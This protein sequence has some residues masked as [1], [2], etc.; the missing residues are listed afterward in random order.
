LDS[1]QGGFFVLPLIY[2]F[3]V[4]YLILTLRVLVMVLFLSRYTLVRLSFGPCTDLVRS[5]F[6]KHPNEVR[7]RCERKRTESGRRV[8]GD[9][10][11]RRGRCP[12]RPPLLPRPRLSVSVPAGVDRGRAFPRW[13]TLRAAFWPLAEKLS[14][15]GIASYVRSA[16]NVVPGSWK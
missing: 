6:G 10:N 15:N 4:S 7:T 8:D 14:F 16:K 2:S 5:C 3:S 12:H 13:R 11:G 9:Q 1:D